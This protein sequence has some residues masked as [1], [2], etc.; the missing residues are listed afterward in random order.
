MFINAASQVVGNASVKCG[1]FL[2]G[3]NVNEKHTTLYTGVTNELV[4]RVYEH[5]ESL[6]EGFTKNINVKNWFITKY[7][8]T[9]TAQ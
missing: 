6:V 7:L 8:R 9:L 1:V 2:V 3:Q 5:Q 4:R